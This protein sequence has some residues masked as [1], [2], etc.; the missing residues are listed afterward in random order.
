[1]VQKQSTSS[2]AVYDIEGKQ[3]GVLAMPKK[4]F[5]MKVA[6]ALLA[7]YVRMYLANQRQGTQSVR[8][9]AEVIGS[10]RKI[11]KQKGTGRARHGSRKAPI[12]VGGGS[13]HAPKPRSYSMKMNKKQKIKALYGSLSQKV[14]HGQITIVDGFLDI[15]AKTKKMIMILKNLKLDQKKNILLVAPKNKNE[16]LYKAS[17][18]INKITYIDIH[19]LNAYRI[20]QHQHIIF[21]QEALND[22]LREGE[23]S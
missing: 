10:T 15:E 11:Y 9:R 19:S 22:I 13:A 16:S 6:D 14:A 7:Q 4:I 2:I 3:T 21:P 23:I 1:M 18:N 12:F 8:T 5:E 17:R 20:L